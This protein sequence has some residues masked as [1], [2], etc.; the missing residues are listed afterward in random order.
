MKIRRFRFLMV[1]VVFALAGGA[2]FSQDI[3]KLDLAV[4]QIVPPDAQLERVATGFDKWL[5]GPV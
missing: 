2:A 5:E 4:D 3:Q 1:F